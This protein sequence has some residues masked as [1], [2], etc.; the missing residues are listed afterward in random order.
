VSEYKEFEGLSVPHEI[1]PGSFE[2]V[3]RYMLRGGKPRDSSACYIRDTIEGV[4]GYEDVDCSVEGER[5]FC[6]ECILGRGYEE[7]FKKYMRPRRVGVIDP[8]QWDKSLLTRIK[9]IQAFNSISTNHILKLKTLKE[10]KPMDKNI[11]KAFEKTEDAVLVEKHLGHEINENF[12]TGLVV[13]HYADP[14]LAEAKRREA[15]EEDRQHG[16]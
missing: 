8:L 16:N 3:H 6:E 1:K 4:N 14:I 9:G 7:T 11:V 2:K 15:K 5:L 12:I 13:Q 10:D